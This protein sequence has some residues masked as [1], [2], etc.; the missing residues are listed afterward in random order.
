MSIQQLDTV[1]QVESSDRAT[2]PRARRDG[3]ARTVAVLALG[4]TAAAHV[5]VAVDHVGEIPYLGYTFY[6][7]VLLCAAVLG[8]LLVESRTG[9]WRIAL[10]LSVG[11]VLAYVASRTVGLPLAEDDIGDW[12]NPLGMVAVAA[13]L[14]VA[15]VSV[16]VLR[17]RRHDH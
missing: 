2:A 1:V 6:A 10:L 7:L 11:T 5:P 16:T 12:A 4:V 8:S 3:V 14:V 15:A 17:H 9:A 13:E